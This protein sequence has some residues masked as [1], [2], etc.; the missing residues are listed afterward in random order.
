MHEILQPNKCDLRSSLKH[1]QS[2]RL[3]LLIFYST[4]KLVSFQLSEC[5]AFLKNRN[6]ATERFLR[7]KACS[8][9][10]GSGCA[11][12]ALFLIL[13]SKITAEAEK[14]GTI[15]SS[16][17]FSRNNISFFWPTQWLPMANVDEKRFPQNY[18]QRQV[19]A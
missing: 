15:S 11:T 17:Y 16:T 14:R 12:R 1:L 19:Y 3:R 4:E 5:K 13:L 18:R 9:F 6:K 7:S 2:I 10:P 8:E